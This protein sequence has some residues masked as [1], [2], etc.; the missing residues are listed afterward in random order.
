MQCEMIH[1]IQSNLKSKEGSNS[2]DSRNPLLSLSLRIIK[3]KWQDKLNLVHFIKI[4]C[5][6]LW[7]S[8]EIDC[9]I[10][11]TKTFTLL[12][13]LYW[14]RKVKWVLSNIC[15]KIKQ[16][17]S[18]KINRESRKGKTVLYFDYKQSKS[19]IF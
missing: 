7:N 13:K 18:F 8:K 15:H 1:C 11:W 12:T 10:K 9:S 19:T 4:S 6:K 14:R 17:S 3:V 2:K 16:N 5:S